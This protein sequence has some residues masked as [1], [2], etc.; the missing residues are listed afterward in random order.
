MVLSVS[1]SIVAA[2]LLELVSMLKFLTVLLEALLF[3]TEAPEFKFSLARPW[4]ASDGGG[5]TRGFLLFWN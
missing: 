4:A 1:E 2:F 3:L 5:V